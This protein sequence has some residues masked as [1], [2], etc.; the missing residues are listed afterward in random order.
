[1][2]QGIGINALRAK[3]SKHPPDNAFAGAD[4]ASQSNNVLV[5]CSAHKPGILFWGLVHYRQPK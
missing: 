4:I 5:L 1:M 2:P 3:M